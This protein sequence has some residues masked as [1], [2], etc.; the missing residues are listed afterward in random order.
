MN[1]FRRSLLL[2]SLPGLVGACGQGGK[3]PA[4]AGADAGH[5]SEDRAA[6][7]DRQPERRALF[8]DL[9]SHTAFSF[10]A[11]TYDVR[12]TPA[13][14]YR[15]ARG[16][17]I[18]LPPLDAEG[19]P[20]LPVKLARP[21]DFAAVTDHSEYLGET[22]LCSTP[23]SPAYESATC[24]SYRPP[25]R[26]YLDFNV[27][28]DPPVRSEICGDGGTVCADAAGPVWKAIQDAAEGAYDRSAACA[29]TTFVAYEYSLAPFGTNLHRN[30]IFR[31]AAALP[32]P[33]S[34]YDAP[35]P[36]QLWKLLDEG[37]GKAGTGCDVLAIPH[38]SNLS[39][40][41]M[42]EVEY[43]GADGAADEKAQAAFRAR[44]EPL[45]E[46]YQHKGDSECLNGLATV[47]GAP[48]EL[49]E[50]EKLQKPPLIDC[51]VDGVGYGAFGGVGCTSWRDYLRNTLVSGLQEE[52][53]IGENP[54][55]LGIIASTDT[56]NGTPGKVD[57]R[58]FQGH[59]GI[60]DQS[61]EDQLAGATL[62]VHPLIA[63]PGGLAGV[64]AEE[65]SRDAIFDALR[66]RE[67]FGTSGPRLTVRLFGGWGYPDDA[68]GR[69]DMVSRG[70]RDGVPMG[71]DLPAR[72]AGSGAPRLIAS[73]M[74]DPGS[75]EGPGTPLQRLQIIKV[76]AGA[77][78]AAHEKVFDVA[79]D[80]GNGATVD[81]VTCEPKGAGADTLCAVWTDPEFDATSH[82]AYYLRA[83]ENPTC[84]WSAVLC[85]SLPPAQQ[86]A[87][88][89]DNLGVPSTVQERA[90]SSPIWYA[91]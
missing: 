55:K 28:I 9:H 42:F 52:A 72:P 27:G 62:A 19:H 75:A 15:F 32:T 39:N 85:A 6:C 53:R 49:C 48:D 82:V 34:V 71:G 61:P 67:T 65:N 81:P 89:C 31:N 44:M 38:N 87:L 43:P 60:S 56:H 29:F 18:H 3:V 24:Q 59:L 68:C 33:L 54:Y 58:T 63:S 83:V 45:A 66:R 13:D 86:A 51:G 11:W 84:R 80:A 14:A 57:E 47:P 10:D 2:C 23:G 7:A 50:F 22:S 20:T 12:A 35:T 16:E 1:R 69:A 26:S 8:G 37:C 21:L 46:I 36:Q 91:P 90:W 4:D 78:G 70:Y 76:W 73:A 88:K 5:Y 30:V 64:W 77:D 40:G 41:R 79:G 17:T 74:R 25:M